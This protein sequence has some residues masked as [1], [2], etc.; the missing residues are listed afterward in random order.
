[1][2]FGPGHSVF[3]FHLLC[4]VPIKHNVRSTTQ[5][6]LC[7]PKACSTFITIYVLWLVVK[8]TQEPGLLF[9]VICRPLLQLWMELKWPGTIW[10]SVAQE[11][12]AGSPLI[13]RQSGVSTQL[14]LCLKSRTPKLLLM[15]VPCI[16]MYCGHL[17][18]ERWIRAHRAGQHLARCLCLQ[19][20]E[21]GVNGCKRP[22]VL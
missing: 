12:G 10:S 3:H 2:Q 13:G 16:Q 6:K 11:G 15:A 20:Y 5:K 8:H 18:G 22:V 21:G 14:W 4:F 17:S 19:E 1:M 9:T 7:T